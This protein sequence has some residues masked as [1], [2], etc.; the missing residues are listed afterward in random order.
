MDL[1]NTARRAW[2]PGTTMAPGWEDRRE[3]LLASP[4][5]STMAGREASI[6]SRARPSSTSPPGPATS[7]SRAAE[8]V[9]D[10]GRRDPTD[11]SPDM[12]EAARRNGEARGLTNVEYRV[13]D[14]EQMD[15]DDDSVDG[16]V[17]RWGYMLMADPA[18][19]LRRQGGCCATAA[20]W[21]SSSG[22]RPTA[23]PGR[24]YPR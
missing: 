4:G 13:L 7:A 2:R 11:F 14:A 6:R 22:R 10:E 21:A 5:G 17:C 18:A 16:V 15:L 9:G 23:T 3:W 1:Q 20:R 12:L 24:R 19:A 8:R